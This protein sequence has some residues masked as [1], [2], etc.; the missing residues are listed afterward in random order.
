M[1]RFQEYYDAI[2]SEMGG[3]CLLIYLQTSTHLFEYSNKIYLILF[4]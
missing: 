2:C 4:E 3:K 1:R